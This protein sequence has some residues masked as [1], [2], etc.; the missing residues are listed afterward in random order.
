MTLTIPKDPL[1]ESLPPMPVGQAFLEECAKHDD[2][3]PRR[4]IVTSRFRDRPHDEHRD[5]LPIP[6]TGLASIEIKRWV[7]QTQEWPRSTI[8]LQLEREN[9]G[10]GK[11]WTYVTSGT[12]QPLRTDQLVLFNQQEVHLRHM[13][14]MHGTAQAQP[15]VLD[16]ILE[17]PELLLNGLSTLRTLLERGTE[18]IIVGAENL[19]KVVTAYERG[20]G[21]KEDARIQALKRTIDQQHESMK[22]Q[23]DLMMQLAQELRETKLSVA[24]LSKAAQAPEERQKQDDQEGA[25]Q[26]E[27]EKEAQE[28]GE[29][30]ASSHQQ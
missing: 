10:G 23:N 24:T 22:V 21:S 27:R 3:A 28:I 8:H 2:Y 14:M 7:Y 16:R 5:T 17:N 29:P 11:R 6:P 20:R 4:L 25:R 12:I 15:G 13:M 30:Q 18:D 1:F 19:G 26:D 9:E